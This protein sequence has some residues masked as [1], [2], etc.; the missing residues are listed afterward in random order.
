MLGLPSN[1]DQYLASERIDQR[2]AGLS[3]RSGTLT[4]RQVTANVQRLLDE[5]A[6]AVAAASLAEVFKKHDAA[7]NFRALVDGL[8]GRPSIGQA[9]PVGIQGIVAGVADVDRDLRH[10]AR[11]AVR[12]RA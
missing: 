11:P 5:P 2:G 9:E 12:Q 3:L 10:G 4:A 1:L 8:C 7:A 6:F